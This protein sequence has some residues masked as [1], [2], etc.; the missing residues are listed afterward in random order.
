MFALTLNVGI[1]IGYI[2]STY[3]P[4][5]IIPCIVLPIPV[6]YL[7]MATYYPETPQYLLRKGKEEKAL[8]SF[9]FYKNN[10][11][12]RDAVTYMVVHNKFEELK[13]AIKHQESKSEKITAADIC[14]FTQ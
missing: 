5:H 10:I 13:V 4:Y 3:V 6:L 2:L 11:D 9:K 14:K 7:I 1:L 8:K 12:Q